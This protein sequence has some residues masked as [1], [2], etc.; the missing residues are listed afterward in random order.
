VFRNCRFLGWQDTVFINRGRQYFEGCYICGHVDFI[1][2]GATA[3]F[4]KC[5]IHC[6]GNGYITAASTP[7]NQQFG[8]V[9]S[10]C[11]I[12]AAPSIKTYLGRPW[13]DFSCVT[14]LNTEMPDAVSPEGWQNW[15]LP[16]RE[17][18]SRYSEFGSSGA[19]GSIQG[20]V[21]WSRQLTREQAAQ[22]SA[23]RV[24]GGTDGWN[25]LKTPV[26]MNQSA[27]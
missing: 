1:F 8:F 16:A 22:L 15:N 10:N 14:F 9:F 12:T 24:L 23:P 4:E 17:K 27:R 13:R 25:P 3:Y 6:L 11:R 7:D 5:H 18:T 2:G 20:R 21:K 26:R 19:G